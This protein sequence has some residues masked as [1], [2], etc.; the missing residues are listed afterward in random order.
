[1]EVRTRGIKMGKVNVPV[2]TW[3]SLMTLPST[4]QRSGS[5]APS[6][7]PFLNNYHKRKQTRYITNLRGDD[8]GKSILQPMSKR[9]AEVIGVDTLR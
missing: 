4:W 2:T 3:Q 7:P 8:R 6:L 5:I 1:M 9:K